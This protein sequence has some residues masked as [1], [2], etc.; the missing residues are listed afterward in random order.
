[1]ASRRPRARPA[2]RPDRGAGWVGREFEVT[3]GPV[4]PSLGVAVPRA[5]ENGVGFVS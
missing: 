2:E 3:V 5:P 4:A 1:M